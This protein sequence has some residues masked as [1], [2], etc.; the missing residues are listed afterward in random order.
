MMNPPFD[1]CT[2]DPIK[3]TRF[4]PNRV[5]AYIQGNGRGDFLASEATAASKHPR[6]SNL[7][8]DF[9]PVTSITYPCTYCLYGMEA[10]GC[11]GGQ[12]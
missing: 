2:S 7:T 11:L 9:K 10:F 3:P 1:Q 4:G 12:I 5:A 8:P 6:R